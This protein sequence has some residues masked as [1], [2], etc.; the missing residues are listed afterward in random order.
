MRL[1]SLTKTQIETLA[2]NIHNTD[3]YAYT[4]ECL[5]HH[6]AADQLHADC[7]KPLD[8]KP[9]PEDGRISHEG[10]NAQRRYVSRALPPWDG[11]YFVMEK[12]GVYS[13]KTSLGSL[14]GEYP[15]EEAAK[16]AMQ[17]IYS[18]WIHA[19]LFAPPSPKT[20]EMGK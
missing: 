15:S 6:L 18:A 8:W 12:G 1:T 10:Q 4:I 3:D 13:L 11:A 20:R 2:N 19:A 9:H 17:S 14:D 16:A 7:V 5:T